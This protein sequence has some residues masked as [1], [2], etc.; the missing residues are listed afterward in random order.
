[1]GSTASTYWAASRWPTCGGSKLPPKSAI[2]SGIEQHR[3][4]LFQV[5]RALAVPEG[6]E[7]AHGR[8]LLDRRA[9]TRVARQQID[10]GLVVDKLV[11]FRAPAKLRGI[12]RPCMDDAGDAEAHR[13]EPA[14]IDEVHLHAVAA[15]FRVLVPG[16]REGTW[17]ETDA[18]QAFS[19]ERI[20]EPLA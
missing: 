18:E 13:V 10:R 11:F 9:K 14:R 3:R 8:A 4:A 2:S 20:R 1:M 6:A 12:L 5:F 16:G 7:I 19:G 15:R 17:P